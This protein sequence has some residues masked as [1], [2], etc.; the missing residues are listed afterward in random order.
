MEMH[1]HYTV[2]STDGDFDYTRLVIAAN[3]Q[4]AIQT[5]REH[6]PGCTVTG[7]IPNGKRGVRYEQPYR[8]PEASGTAGNSG[9]AE[10]ENTK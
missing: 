9:A 10:K 2:F 3:K 1:D 5:H 6:F 8:G 7:V 4:D